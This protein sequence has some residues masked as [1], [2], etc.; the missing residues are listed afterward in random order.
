MRR[1]ADEVRDYDLAALCPSSPGYYVRL[2]WELWRGT[3]FIR[4]PE[5]PVRSPEDEEV[6]ILRLPKTPDL[7]LT[8]PL[9]ADWRE[10]ELW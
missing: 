2:G 8:A 1:L 9:S 10:G 3:L 4:T 5:G 6:M 7:D